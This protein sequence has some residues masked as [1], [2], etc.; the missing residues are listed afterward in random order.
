[1]VI[2]QKLAAIQKVRKPPFQFPNLKLNLARKQ[3]DI[4][5]KNKRKMSST[6]SVLTRMSR[7]KMTHVGNME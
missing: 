4:I 7:I 5:F 6:M 1:M 2:I 3:L